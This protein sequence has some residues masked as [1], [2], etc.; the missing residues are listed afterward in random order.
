MPNKH[1]PISNWPKEL[2]KEDFSTYSSS[3]SNAI[4]QW[5]EKTWNTLL[6]KK[7]LSSSRDKITPE[8]L[9]VIQE[10]YNKQVDLILMMEELNL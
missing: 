10:A 5:L 7:F 8:E 2:K 3:V 6:R 4:A 1:S 9:E